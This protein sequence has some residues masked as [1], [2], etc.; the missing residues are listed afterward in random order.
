MALRVLLTV[1]WD[2]LFSQLT[3]TDHLILFVSCEIASLIEN[4]SI[5]SFSQKQYELYGNLNIS[6]CNDLDHSR[7]VSQGHVLRNL[8]GLFCCNQY[9][10]EME[11]FDILVFRVK[12]IGY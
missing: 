4:L 7:S 10:N 8:S 3:I 11:I 6:W 5:T 9:L 12:L 2:V 1:R